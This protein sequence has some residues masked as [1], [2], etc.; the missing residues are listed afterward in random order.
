[1]F[2]GLPRRGPS[3]SPGIPGSKLLERPPSARAPGAPA[4][5]PVGLSTTT[6]PLFHSA[7][8]LLLSLGIALIATDSTPAQTS[9]SAP[10]STSTSSTGSSALE[11]PE[12]DPTLAT[13]M[14]VLLIGGVLLL[15][16]RHRRTVASRSSNQS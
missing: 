3:A 15:T 10:M 12:I 14:V 13:G 4:S 9:S 6:M 11:A 16:S 2:L 1:M 5:A 7:R 8:C